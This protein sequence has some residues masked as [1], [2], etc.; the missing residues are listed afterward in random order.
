VGQSGPLL[1][2]DWVRN[3][4]ESSIWIDHEGAAVV[5]GQEAFVS[6]PYLSLSYD[7]SC[8]KRLAKKLGCKLIISAK[9]HHYPGKTIRLAFL[10]KASD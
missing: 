2:E 8:A 4:C 3:F 10:P 1:F 7:F 6:E 5:N 9:S